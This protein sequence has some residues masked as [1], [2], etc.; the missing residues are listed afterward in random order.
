MEHLKAFVY[1]GVSP[2]EQELLTL[3]EHMGSL[4]VFCGVRV[5]EVLF[6]V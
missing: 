4:P 5:A 3:P 2:V 6:S 1:I